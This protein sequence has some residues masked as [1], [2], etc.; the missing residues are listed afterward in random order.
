MSEP[1]VV[2]QS[3]VQQLEGRLGANWVNLREARR[4]AEEKRAE[5]R[6]MLKGFDSEDTSVVVA[7]SLARDEFT[8]GSDIDWILLVDGQADPS[9]YASARQIGRLISEASAK[10]TGPEGTFG[11]IVFSHNLVHEIGGEDDTNRNLRVE[12]CSSSN[13]RR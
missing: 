3:A 11:S 2:N 6:E 4:L 13:P 8:S 9:H 12:F 5:L 7:G 1:T 10:G